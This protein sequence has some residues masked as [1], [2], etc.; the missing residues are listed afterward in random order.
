M[1][2]VFKTLGDENRLRIINLLMRHELCVCEIVTMLDITQSNASRHLARLKNAGI[3]ESF[4]K[5]Q[6]VYYKIS[7]KFIKDSSILYDF[8]KQRLQDKYQFL[9]DLNKLKSYCQSGFTCLDIRKSQKRVIRYLDEQNKKL[10][11][12]FICIGNSCRSQMAEGFAKQK[13][14]EGRFEIYSA[15]TNPAE[16]VDH[17]AVKVMKEAGVDIS[18][19]FPKHLDSIPG[20][21]DILITMGC[22]VYCPLIPCIINEDWELDDPAGKSTEEFKRIRDLIKARVED[23]NM[24]IRNDFLKSQKIEG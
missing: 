24:K 23:L 13:L 3:I 11:L 17:K 14:K 8:L 20:K 1:V 15:G 12:G 21:L 18:D 4:K 9:S 7:D 10:K 22:N 6:W 5:A 2:E 16:R 19:Q